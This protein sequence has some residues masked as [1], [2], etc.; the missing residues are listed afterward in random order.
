MTLEEVQALSDEELRIRVA[1]L[2]G[3]EY[4]K[5]DSNGLVW[6][7]H[8]VHG[9]KKPKRI[10]PPYAPHDVPRYPQDL[11]TM[12][13]AELATFGPSSVYNEK[14]EPLM[15][16]LDKVTGGL[17]WSVYTATARQR[18]EAFV[19]AMKGTE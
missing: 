16:A 2:C 6:C 5:P 1:K 17:S 14:W 11:N 15:N 4:K 3:W 18:A 12:H 19:L 7:K 13:E 9:W 8:P 10:Q